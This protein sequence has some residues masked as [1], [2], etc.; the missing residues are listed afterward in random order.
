[1]FLSLTVSIIIE[2]KDSKNSP[3]IALAKVHLIW[4]TL[5]KA[6]NGELLLP[7]PIVCV[8]G[9]FSYT[10]TTISLSDLVLVIQQFRIITLVKGS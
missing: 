3:L 7:F 2:G 4:Q 9:V 8:L 6:I 1:M 5:V 10:G